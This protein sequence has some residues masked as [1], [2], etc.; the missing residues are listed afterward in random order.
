M[1]EGRLLVHIPSVAL[2]LLA[3]GACLACEDVTESEP[4][5]GGSET[6]DS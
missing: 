6:A 5:G 1:G 3:L 4:F 2:R